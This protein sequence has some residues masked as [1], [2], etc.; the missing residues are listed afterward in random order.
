MLAR[1][2]GLA[3]RPDLRRR[4]KYHDN[5]EMAYRGVA[6]TVAPSRRHICRHQRLCRRNFGRPVYNAAAG[7][8]TRNVAAIGVGM[9]Y[10]H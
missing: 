10:W 4:D 2:R 7:I 8:M 6:D 3:A 5:M 9:K 1:C